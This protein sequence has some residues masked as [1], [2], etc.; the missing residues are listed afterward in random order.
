MEGAV[1]KFDGKEMNGRKIKMVKA[2]EDSGSRSRSRFVV[3]YF[4]KKALSID[5]VH[6]MAV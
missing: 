1:E 2:E 4:T 6:F 5:T 3:G